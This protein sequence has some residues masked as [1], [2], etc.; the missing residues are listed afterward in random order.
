MLNVVV[1]RR[2]KD[3]HKPC[4]GREPPLRRYRIIQFVT[5][6][7]GLDV[8]LMEGSTVGHLGVISLIIIEEGGG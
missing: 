1:Q 8:L 5:D 7:F 6:S 4:A 3:P 2:R